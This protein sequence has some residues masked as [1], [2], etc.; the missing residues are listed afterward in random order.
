MSYYR[1]KKLIYDKLDQCY[2]SG[3]ANSG[4]DYY[5]HWVTL[6][7]QV[8]ICHECEESDITRICAIHLKSQDCIL[9][10]Y[11]DYTEK[12]METW[13]IHR[14]T[15]RSFY[16]RDNWI[17]KFVNAWKR[18]V[19]RKKAARKIQN[20]LLEIIYRPGHRGFHRVFGDYESVLALEK[21]V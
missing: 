3:Y 1:L 4:A 21:V 10:D 20:F 7:E 12:W 5:A 14:H 16:T 18:F 8:T 17:R 6:F 2:P 19:K 9:V 15:G 11:D 13:R